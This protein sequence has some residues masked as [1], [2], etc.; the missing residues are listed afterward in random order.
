MQNPSGKDLEKA[1]NSLANLVNN[2]AFK[3]INGSAKLPQKRAFIEGEMQRI[4]SFNEQL[5]KEIDRYIRN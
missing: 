4:S 1:Q 5:E 2:V 3:V